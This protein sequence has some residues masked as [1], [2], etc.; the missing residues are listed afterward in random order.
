MKNLSI[1]IL[2]VS[3]FAFIACKNDKTAESTQPATA[4]LAMPPASEP[5]KVTMEANVGPD[6]K[7][8]ITEVP[9]NAGQTTP[10]SATPANVVTPDA[11]AAPVGPT[12]SIQFEETTYDFGTKPNDKGKIDH[13]FK[14]KNTGKE[15]CIIS[16]VK[17]SCGCT[18]PEWP[19]TPIAPGAVGEIKASFDPNGKKGPQNKTITVSANTNPPNTSLVVKGNLTG[20]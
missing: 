6:G 4:P 14:F 13:I 11:N 19:K 3:L 15:P 5:Q 7:T 16:N 1:L 17:A 8:V 10:S 20:K 18:T 9:S 2:S 12:T